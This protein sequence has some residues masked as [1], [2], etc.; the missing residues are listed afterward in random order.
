MPASGNRLD[1][2]AQPRSRSPHS[3]RVKRSTYTLPQFVSPRCVGDDRPITTPT[4]S[5]AAP[6]PI[7]HQR[8]TRESVAGQRC[9]CRSRREHIR[10]YRAFMAGEPS[11]LRDEERLHRQHAGNRGRQWLRA[12]AAVACVVLVGFIGIYPVL[13]ASITCS[14]PLCEQ[15]SVDRSEYAYLASEVLVL[16]ASLVCVIRLGSRARATWIVIG[17][18]AVTAV[19]VAWAWTFFISHVVVG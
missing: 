14:P 17:C 3:G 13:F 16:F 7:S 8:P 6:A 10:H 5:S 4:S 12:A 2:T 19:A 18:T 1:A 11:G 9:T 15:A